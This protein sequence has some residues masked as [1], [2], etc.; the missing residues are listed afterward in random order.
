MVN[1]VSQQKNSVCAVLTGPGNDR[2]AAPLSARWCS[3]CIVGARRCL[4]VGSKHLGVT[5][6]QRPTLFLRECVY[7]GLSKMKE[8]RT[9]SWVRRDGKRRDRRHTGAPVW[10]RKGQ[11]RHLRPFPTLWCKDIGGGGGAYHGT[12]EQP[13]RR[14]LVHHLLD[15]SFKATQLKSGSFRVTV[16]G[17]PKAL[18]IFC[19]KKNN[20]SVSKGCYK[21]R[22]QN[23]LNPPS[24]R[25]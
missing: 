16:D 12:E 5:T 17:V 21:E 14:L 6:P 19:I 1:L 4:P 22:C 13:K 23:L 25:N 15:H 7:V 20:L 3:A 2:L 9:S 18:D 8:L 10:P 24:K 11:K